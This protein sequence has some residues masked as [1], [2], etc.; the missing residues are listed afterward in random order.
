M[1]GTDIKQWG[2]YKHKEIQHEFNFKPIT[3]DYKID[4]DNNTFDIV[5]S[6]YVLHHI[7]NLTNTINEIKRVLKPNGYILIIEHDNHDD[8][9]N[10]LIDIEHLL[11]ATF[12]DKNKKFIE[13]PEFSKYYNRLEWDY[14]FSQHGFKHINSELLFTGVS[15]DTNY[16]NMC[17]A[18]YQN[19]K[20]T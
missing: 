7:D 20:Q 12:I 11:Y 8:L 13:K 10:L 5:S 6:F 2:P 19:K 17:Y 15:H 1:F 14:I 9:D 18:I 16:D 3:A 4:Y